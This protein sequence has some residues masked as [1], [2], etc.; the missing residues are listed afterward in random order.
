ME[1]RIIHCIAE[2]SVRKLVDKANKL[3]IKKEDIVQI[4]VLGGQVHMIYYR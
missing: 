4:F 1:E 2:D 3:S